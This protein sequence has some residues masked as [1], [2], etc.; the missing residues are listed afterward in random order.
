MS[1]DHLL[2][3]PIIHLVLSLFL[4]SISFLQVE[5]QSKKYRFSDRNAQKLANTYCA[6]VAV[7]LGNLNKLLAMLKELQNA[8]AG[9]SFD[10]FSIE[11]ALQ[12]PL[13]CLPNA[14]AYASLPGV[15]QLVQCLGK[16]SVNISTPSLDGISSCL[17]GLL[18]QFGGSI[19]GLNP[20][21]ILSCVGN[22]S[23]VF[24]LSSIIGQIKNIIAALKGILS[25][26]KNILPG[27]QAMVS[28]DFLK[29][30]GIMANICNQSMVFKAKKSSKS[31]K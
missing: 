21:S 24:D 3:L 18:P 16:F 28:K 4:L 7:N 30:I 23:A 1:K 2:K 19:D 6:H 17:G 29:N 27:I 12:S 14:S 22:V 11:G 25:S 10:A 8:L 13:N 20:G 9:M 15:D 5:A 26:L 31:T